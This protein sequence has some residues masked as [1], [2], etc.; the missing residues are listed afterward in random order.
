M[1]EFLGGTWEEE[2][3]GG[4]LRRMFWAAAIETQRKRVYFFK[5]AQTGCA[6][7]LLALA[8]AA[9]LCKHRVAS[10]PGCVL[11]VMP[12]CLIGSLRGATGCFFLVS[13]VLGESFGD[14][15]GCQVIWFCLLMSICSFPSGPSLTTK[16]N[17]PSLQKTFLASVLCVFWD[18]RASLISCFKSDLRQAMGGEVSYPP[19]I[20]SN[21]S[22]PQSQFLFLSEFRFY[23]PL[24]MSEFSFCSFHSICPDT[25]C[26]GATHVHAELSQYGWMPGARL[27]NQQITPSPQSATA[28]LRLLSINC[29]MTSCLETSFA[30]GSSTPMHFLFPVK[31]SIPSSNSRQKFSYIDTYCT[32]TLYFQED[33][34]IFEIIYHGSL[35]LPHT[36]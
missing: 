31:K 19:A 14:G 36:T 33:S 22:S 25:L 11:T 18:K 27:H 28:L 3:K 16:R 4:W 10:P 15:D 13:V 8:Q 17:L 6:C 20:S 21:S 29:A 26:V 12:Y 24:W 30:S 32:Q 23:F 2:S 35:P 9:R 7:G 1:C 34:F 5:L